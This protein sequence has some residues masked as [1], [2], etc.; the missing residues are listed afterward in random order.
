MNSLKVWFENWKYKRIQNK[1]KKMKDNLDVRE[2]IKS[3]VKVGLENYSE[4]SA[5]EK[6]LAEIRDPKAVNSL[7]E[8][9]NDDDYKTRNEAIRVLVNIGKPSIEQL[10]LAIKDKRSNVKESAAK[11]LGKI[12]GPELEEHLITSLKNEDEYQRMLSYRALVDIKGIEEAESILESLLKNEKNPHIKLGIVDLI[13]NQSILYDI[14]INDDT[15]NIRQSAINKIKD[16]L[17]LD[18]IV[19][20]SRDTNIQ[21]IARQKL[22]K[23]N[24]IRNEVARV[25]ELLKV[26]MPLNKIIELLG[27]PSRSIGGTDVVSMTKNIGASISSSATGMMGGKIFMEWDRPEGLYKLV[28]EDGKLARIYSAPEGILS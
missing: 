7:I 28:I 23:L 11:A 10:L 1:V 17:L 13:K 20:N 2:L 18:N 5:A 25:G 19:K 9:L 12:G 21:K 14:A 22:T 27:P 15:E 3:S 8:I 24:D 4:R 6:A 26:G 16:G